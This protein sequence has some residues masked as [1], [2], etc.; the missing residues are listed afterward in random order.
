MHNETGLMARFFYVAI[1]QAIYTNKKY[2]NSTNTVIH[3]TILNF[4]AQKSYSRLPFDFFSIFLP[5]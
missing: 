2:Q 5:F 4:S 1:A 3:N